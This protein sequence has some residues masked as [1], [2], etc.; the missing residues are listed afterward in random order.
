VLARSPISNTL[1]IRFT[2]SPKT[3][4]ALKRVPLWGLVEDRVVKVLNHIWQVIFATPDPNVGWIIE[5]TLLPL[6]ER[7]NIILSQ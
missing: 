3:G 6:E 4:R 2:Q 5:N 1:N 7:L